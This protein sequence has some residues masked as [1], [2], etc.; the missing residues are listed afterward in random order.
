MTKEEIIAEVLDL[1]E[2]MHEDD[3]WRT[4]KFPRE[5]S[6]RFDIL[7]DDILTRFQ[8]SDPRSKV[9]S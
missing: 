7:K 3:C 4:A 5:C 9:K 2:S 8:M 1:V 6:C